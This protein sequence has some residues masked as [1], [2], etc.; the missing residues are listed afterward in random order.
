[1]FICVDSRPIATANVT[2]GTVVRTMLFV[3][4]N[5][6][7]SASEIVSDMADEIIITG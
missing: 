4:L 1:M 5:R 3:T 6:Y 2:I 7:T